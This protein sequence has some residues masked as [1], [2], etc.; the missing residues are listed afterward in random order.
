MTAILFRQAGKQ[1]P[2]A[3]HRAFATASLEAGGAHLAGAVTICGAPRSSSARSGCAGRL[4]SVAS[5]VLA[6]RRAAWRT[7]S[8]PAG[9]CAVAF[10]FG[11]QRRRVCPAALGSARAGPACAA[12]PQFPDAPSNPPHARRCAQA[13][14]QPGMAGEG[15]PD[16]RL[17]APPAVV[18]SA[19]AEAADEDMASPPE[20]GEQPRAGATL[21]ARRFCAP[22]IAPPFSRAWRRKP[23]RLTRW[24]HRAE[25]APVGRG[26]GERRGGRERL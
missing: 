3:S 26:G 22:K 24:R 8:G 23:P 18:A 16:A 6:A 12:R 9:A 19:A 2:S 4:L 11:P 13:N 25:R 14:K 10:V 20:S 7:R 1:A 15:E 17:D 5:G 21:A